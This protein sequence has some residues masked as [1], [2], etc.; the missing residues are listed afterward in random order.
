M[1]KRLPED[2]ILKFCSVDILSKNTKIVHK[3]IAPNMTTLKRMI[4]FTLLKVFHI[5]IALVIIY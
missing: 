3:R 4:I 2:L 1:A 5:L